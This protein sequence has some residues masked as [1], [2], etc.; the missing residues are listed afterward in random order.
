MSLPNL[1]TILRLLL[2]PILVISLLNGHFLLAI[3]I[4]S[5]AGLSDILDGL[6]ARRLNQCTNLGSCLDPI[7]DKVLISSS[8]VLLAWLRFIPNWLAVVVISRDVIILLGSLLLFLFNIHFEVRPSL[9][10]KMTTAFQMI[11]IFAT[12]LA[13]LSHIDFPLLPLLW[14]TMGLTLA[15]GTQYL[16][17]GYRLC[18]VA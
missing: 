2:A 14:S 13:Q 8:F 10:G 3:I 15:S 16:Y 5:I 11:T 18:K 12:L 6:L 4:V 9:L 17:R 7:A 1:I